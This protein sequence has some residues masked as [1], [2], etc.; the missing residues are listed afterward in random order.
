[1][2]LFVGRR[3]GVS[4][5]RLSLYKSGLVYS[6]STGQLVFLPPK[7]FGNRCEYTIYK[8]SSRFARL[9]LKSV[10]LRQGVH[11][12]PV[13]LSRL[14]IQVSTVRTSYVPTARH[15]TCHI[16]QGSPPIVRGSTTQCGKELVHSHSSL[17]LRLCNF[18]QSQCL[19]PSISR[20]LY[21][22]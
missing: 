22:I 13:H 9:L 19:P 8:P 16:Q 21:V 6:F 15:P 18:M 5:G 12:N 4:H 17:F 2:S 20:R 1:M 14:S 10:F 3:S 7:L 11:R